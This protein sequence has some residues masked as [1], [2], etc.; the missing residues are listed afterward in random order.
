[1]TAL[2][3][4]LPDR[5]TAGWCKAMNSMMT[6]KDPVTGDPYVA[7]TVFQRTGPGAM[8]GHDGWDAFG[9]SGVVGQMRSPDIEMFEITSP[10]FFEYHEYDTDSAGAGRWRG[11]LGTRSAW[12]VDGVESHGVTL[13][14]AAESEGAEPGRGLDGGEDSGLNVMRLELPDGGTYEWGSKEIIDTPTGTVIVSLCGGGAGY[15][16]PYL[17]PAELVAQEVRNE[18]TSIDKARR[19]YGVVIHPDTLELDEE[20]TAELRNNKENS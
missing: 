20:A 15:G 8:R 1:M 2:A 19:S 7:L 5:V 18:I 4:A 13:G 3:D 9:F 16:D 12:R 17:R 6:G 11:G 10:H 14:E